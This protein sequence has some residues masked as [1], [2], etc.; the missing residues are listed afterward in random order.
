MFLKSWFDYTSKLLLLFEC[1]MYAL[2]ASVTTKV[3]NYYHAASVLDPH[4]LVCGSGALS[5]FFSIPIRIPDP[6][7]G[8]D[9]KTLLFILFYFVK[10]SGTVRI[11]I[12]PYRSWSWR[13]FLMRICVD[14]DPKNCISWLKCVLCCCLYQRA[15]WVAAAPVC[16]VPLPLLSVGRGH[17]PPHR[18]QGPR[19]KLSPRDH[20]TLAPFLIIY[21]AKRQER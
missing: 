13:P 1:R 21:S 5:Q 12:I 10:P 2:F 7:P 14:P 17:Q 15:A 9:P 20:V 11:C 3:N 19:G 18:G 8:G 4:L 6:D 16:G